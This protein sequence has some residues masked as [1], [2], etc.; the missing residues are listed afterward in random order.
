MI[1]NLSRIFILFGE[2]KIIIHVNLLIMLFVDR[3]GIRPKLKHHEIT[4][5]LELP[6]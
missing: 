4:S 6:M 1:L 3:N 5:Y 2:L